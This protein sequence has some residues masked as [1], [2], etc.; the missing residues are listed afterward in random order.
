MAEWLRNGLQNRVRGF[1]SRSDLQLR[2]VEKLFTTGSIPVETS[3][4]IKE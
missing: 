1:D 3:K 2:M 4:I